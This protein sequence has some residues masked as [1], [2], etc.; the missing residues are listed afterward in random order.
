MSLRSLHIHLIA[1]IASLFAFASCSDDESFTTDSNAKLAFSQDTIAFDTIFTTIASST[2][3]FNVYNR[4]SSGLRI[5]SVELESGGKSGFKMNV[6]GQ[7][8]STVKTVEIQKKDSI[9]IFLEVKLPEV[10]GNAPVKVTDRIIFTLESGVKQSVALEVWG[11]NCQQMK[12][13]VITSDTSFSNDLPIIVYDSLVIKEG[14]T[15]T[16]P[17][18]TTLCIHNY[19]DINVHGNLHIEGTADKPVIIRG[20]RMDRLFSYLPYD[21]LE[22]QW[23]GIRVF[24]SCTDLT[25]DHADIHSGSYGIYATDVKGK[26]KITNTSIHN[27]AWDGLSLANCDALIANCQITNCGGDCLSIFGGKQEFYYCTI[28]Q[29]YPWAA[30]RGNAITASNAIGGTIDCII[31]KADFYNCLITGY[32]NDEVMGDFGNQDYLNIHF[33]NSLVNTDISDPTYFTECTG[34]SKD[35]EIRHEKHFRTIDT[36]TYYYDFHLDSLSRAI[37]IASPTYSALYPLDKDGK[38]R[39]DKPSV[40]CYEYVEKK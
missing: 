27:F 2:E 5:T 13:P 24:D 18:G 40:G 12:S 20:D 8:G 33:F 29:F 19:A 9:F 26:I 34:D 35:A 3:R 14:A 17:A 25:I 4:N 37:G 11:Q 7:Y 36:G 22:K 39:S 31:E 16:L 15:L 28:A 30:D 10:E 32:A 6:D 1:I 21:R 38:K 23:S